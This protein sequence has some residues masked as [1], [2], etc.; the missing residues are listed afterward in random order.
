MKCVIC[1]REFKAITGKHLKHHNLT[2]AEYKEEYGEVVSD[3][4]KKLNW[5]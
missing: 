4:Y 3:E 5:K 2:V 1:N